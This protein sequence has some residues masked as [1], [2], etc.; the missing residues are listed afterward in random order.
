VAVGAVKYSI[1]KQ[2]AGRD[3]IFDFNTAVSFEGDSGPYLQYTH[4]R[5]RRV[6]ERAVKS[7]IEPKVEDPDRPG[8]IERLLYR[9]PD[10]VRLAEQEH[11]PQRIAAYAI[12]LAGAFNH[13]YAETPIL[14]S[15]SAAPY[16]VGLAKAVAGVIKNC[17][18]ILGIAAPERM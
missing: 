2:A 6:A 7:G 16:R 5:A 4:A 9:L 1:L 11:T 18:T 3:I 14:D 17:L 12:T 8:D 10:L 13:Y 15:G